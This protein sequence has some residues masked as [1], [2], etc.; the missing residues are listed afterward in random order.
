MRRCSNCVFK[1]T[2]FIA[3]AS[4]RIISCKKSTGLK[5]YLFNKKHYDKNCSIMRGVFY[6]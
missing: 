3:T 6:D 4:M 2:G 5:E 1:N